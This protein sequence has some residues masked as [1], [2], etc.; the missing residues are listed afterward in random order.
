MEGFQL[1]KMI[2][3]G[4]SLLVMRALQCLLVIKLE[5]V[6]LVAMHFK[7]QKNQEELVGKTFSK[8]GMTTNQKWT[9]D[10]HLCYFKEFA[11]THQLNRYSTHMIPLAKFLKEHFESLPSS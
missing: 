4:Y 11:P 9:R 8:A 5:D 1:N 10:C 2:L 7:G 6:R 3:A